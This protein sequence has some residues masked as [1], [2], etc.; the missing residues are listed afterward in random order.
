MKSKIRKMECFLTESDFDSFAYNGS[1]KVYNFLNK[2]LKMGSLPHETFVVLFLNVQNRME[3]YCVVSQ[4]IVDRALIH[5]REVFRLAVMTNCSRVIFAHNHPSGLA[6]V[7]PQDK[8]ATRELVDAA[9]ILGIKVLDHII[10]TSN[11]YLSFKEFGIMPSRK[12]AKF[13]ISEN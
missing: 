12:E 13:S 5:P 11:G 4:G 7:S 9:E 1:A 10:V 2:E 3:G 6:S 8:L